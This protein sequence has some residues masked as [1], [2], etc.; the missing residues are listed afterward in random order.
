LDIYSKYKD[1]GKGLE[2]NGVS[3]GGEGDEALVKSW[4]RCSDRKDC[5]YLKVARKIE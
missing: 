2:I 3:G 5:F 1:K 4:R